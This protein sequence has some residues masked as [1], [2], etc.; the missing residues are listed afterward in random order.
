MTTWRANSP[1]TR[2]PYQTPCLIRTRDGNEYRAELIHLNDKYHSRVPKDKL[3]KWR[4][5]KHNFIEDN[6]VVEWRYDIDI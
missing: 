5:G 1:K 4:L 6:E 3:Y 2:P